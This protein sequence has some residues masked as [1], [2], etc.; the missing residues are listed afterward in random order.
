MKNTEL[1]ADAYFV[2]FLFMASQLRVGFLLERINGTV[3]IP[4]A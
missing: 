4:N 1:I 3:D 2:T